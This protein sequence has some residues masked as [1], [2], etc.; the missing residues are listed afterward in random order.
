M[1]RCGQRV[2]TWRAICRL[3]PM[4]WS[5][6]IVVNSR[7]HNAL[8]AYFILLIQWFIC[9][10]NWLLGFPIFKFQFSIK[11]VRKKKRVN[12][13]KWGKLTN[14]NDSY[15]ELEGKHLEIFVIYFFIY[16]T[17]ANSSLQE[18]TMTTNT[19]ICHLAWR[20]GKHWSLCHVYGVWLYNGRWSDLLHSDTACGYTLHTH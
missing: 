6:K 5:T 16:I 17:L 12:I 8:N 4:F 11:H 15:G 10:L 14:M 20:G 18:L 3:S 9:Y 19:F 7:K 1:R 2:D 13:K